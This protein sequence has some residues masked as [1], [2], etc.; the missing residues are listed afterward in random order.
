MEPV[1]DI[2]VPVLNRPGRV[3]PLLKNIHQTTDRPFTILF[4]ADEHDDA[5]IEA[6]T[7]AGAPFLAVPDGTNYARKINIGYRHTS[8][9]YLFLGADDLRFHRRWLRF[10]LARMGHRIRVVGTNDLF[11]PRVLAGEHST[12]SLVARE[13]I[14]ECG[15]IDEPAKVLHEGYPHE[16]V[17]D[18]FIETAKKRGVWSPEL[19]SVVE[20]SHPYAGKAS[21]DATYQKGWERRAEGLRLYEKR[22]VLWK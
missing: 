21:E 16:Y 9:P 15:T 12:H 13:Y 19:G 6:L 18:E 5:E 10:A 22:R 17:D 4:I 1:V 11:S 20:H 8:A 3:A 2:L 14:D 7:K